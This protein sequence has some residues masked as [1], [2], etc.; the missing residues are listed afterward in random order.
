[1]TANAEA[2]PSTF[3][4]EPIEEEFS[5]GEEQHATV[6]VIEDDFTLETPSTANNLS[7]FPSETSVT[8]ATSSTPAPAKPKAPPAP[9]RPRN[10][11]GKKT[12][13]KGTKKLLRQR[14]MNKKRFGADSLRS[15]PGKDKKRK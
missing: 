13:L 12:L 5:D 7:L 9:Q 14:E 8:P 1:M 11:S 3:P 15:A 6:T 2:G 4:S 10:K